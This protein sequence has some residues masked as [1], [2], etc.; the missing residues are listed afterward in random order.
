MKVP[1]LVW[2]QFSKKSFQ[3]IA[4]LA[5]SFKKSLHSAEKIGRDCVGSLNGSLHYDNL[6]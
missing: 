1:V 4:F 2:E 3:E 6:R 5:T